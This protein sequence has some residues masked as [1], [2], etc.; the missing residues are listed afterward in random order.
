MSRSILL[1]LD[2]PGVATAQAEAACA[3]VCEAAT[4]QLDYRAV[5]ESSAV[6]TAL[7]GDY[8]ALIV[9]PAGLAGAH[10]AAALAQVTTPVVQLWLHNIFANGD[11]TG[12]LQVSGCDLALVC[13]LG[14]AGYTLA[15]RS[16][17]SRVEGA[18]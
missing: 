6:A 16:L 1:V 8:A 7:A 12:P 10:L 14:A 15:A 4:W 18:A 9:N 17:I 3:A 2:A 5:A 11:A 13:G